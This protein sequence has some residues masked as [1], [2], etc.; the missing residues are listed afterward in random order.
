MDSKLPDTGTT[1][2]TVMS[3]LA[4]QHGALNLSQ[5]FPEFEPPL[6]L[7]EALLR[8]V[9]GS[10]NQ[11]APMAGVPALREQIAHKVA[12]QHGCQL[13]PEHEITVTH[14]ATEALFAAVQALVGPGDEVVVF[15]PAYDS[16]EPAVRLAGGFT[17][18]VPLV[19]PDFGI[20]WQ[21][22][23]DAIGP[24]TRLIILNSPHNPTGAV[25]SAADLDRLAGLTR[26][27]N[28]WFLADEVY[29]HMVFDGR[30]H[31][32]LVGHPEL[33]RRSLVVSSFGK[34]V[35]ATGWKVGYCLAPPA[36]TAE[37]R[38]VHQFVCFCI[39]TPMQHALA[40]FLREHPEHWQGLPAFYQARRDAFCAALAGSRF[41]L[42]PA[43]G[44]YFQLLEYSNISA[45]DDLAYAQRLTRE[46]GVAAIP[47]SVFCQVPPAGRYLRFCFAKNDNTLEEAARRLCR[48]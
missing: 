27:W 24:R 36:L 14:G 38:K 5:G 4:E 20:D 47:V 9:N 44:T 17:R 6:A 30:V 13:S 46:I 16:Y 26:A 1:I 28:L 3:R 15:D 29:E 10:S 42:V 2:F 11:Y 23:S 40:D 34:T 8:H 18:H 7:R 39:A 22:L 37:F 33:Y 21:R 35:H 41:G 12:L 25:L 43:H 19:P 45:E 48:L 31:C 32:S